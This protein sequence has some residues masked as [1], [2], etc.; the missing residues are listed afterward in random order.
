MLESVP[1]LLM[2]R[3]AMAAFRSSMTPP[4]QTDSHRATQPTPAVAAMPLR[5]ERIVDIVFKGI[6]GKHASAWL[7]VHNVLGLPLPVAI[8][9]FLGMAKLLKV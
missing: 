2:F 5:H 8:L 1:C 3:G 4:S 6:C 9:W 7:L